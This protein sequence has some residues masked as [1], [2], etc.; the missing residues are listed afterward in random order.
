MSS[1]SEQIKT[2]AIVC[3]PPE[4]GE[5]KWVL[6]EVSLTPPADDEV[7]VELVATG[8]CHTDFICAGYVKSTG[9]KVTKVREGDSVLLSF[10]FCKQCHNCQFGAP[11]F[12]QKWGLINFSGSRGVFLSSESATLGEEIGGSFFGQSSFARVTKVKEVSVVKVTGMLNSDDELKIL[13]PFGCGIQ[14]G[15]GTITELANAQPADM[16]AI[17]GLGAVGLAAV[18]GAKIRGCRTI[19]GIDRVAS[20]LELAKSLGATHTID[21]TNLKG[22]LTEE[23]H[24]ITK[25]TGTTITVDASGAVPLIQQAVEFTANQ[26]KMILVGVPPMDAALQIALVPYI[27]S[28]KSIL[29][30]MEG[31][32]FPEKYVPNLIQWYKAGKLP[33]DKLVKFY[34]AKDYLQAIKDMEDGITVKPVLVW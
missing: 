13:A 15:A 21:T 27:M 5:R 8:I 16:V 14:T 22:T 31:G 18:M 28:G 3:R 23:I 26:G 19:I 10:S 2:Q 30:S 1:I 34:A 17:M 29:G 33:A 24:A 32:V 7:V 12:C 9:A 4:N 20:R 6:E 11:G 25:G